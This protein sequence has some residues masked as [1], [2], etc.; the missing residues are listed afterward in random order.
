[1]PESILKRSWQVTLATFWLQPYFL[2]RVSHFMW[3]FRVFQLA[4]GILVL[5][6][7]SPELSGQEF[8]ELEVQTRNGAIRGLPISWGND[9]VLML[10]SDGWL[11]EFPTR[12]V[13]EHRLSNRSFRPAQA[14][15][16]SRLLTAELGPA[17]RTA[18]AG[19]FLI[20]APGS[21]LPI[22]SERFLALYSGFQNYCATRQITLRQ[23]SFLMPAIVFRTRQE[24]DAYSQ[25]YGHAVT[26]STLGYYSLVTNRIALY[27]FSTNDNTSDFFPT[28][29][30]LIHEATHQAAYNTGIHD[31]L[32]EQPLWTIEGLA[33]L[34]EAPGVYDSGRHHQPEKRINTTRLLGFRQFFPNAQSVSD[35]LPILL[36]DDKY[37]ERD[38]DRAYCLSWAL[39]Y[40]LSER[41]DSQYSAYLRS[42]ASRGPG[43]RYPADERFQQFEAS[44]GNVAIIAR[45]LHE[46]LKQ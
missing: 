27:E 14:E 18:V 12:E 40:F 13:V 6:G 45:D 36:T 44:F 10:R 23:P 25:R 34:F 3:A 2:S 21:S 7:G 39:T 11:A 17:Y 22:W 1:M 5:A 35:V 8:R 9:Q 30:T 37:F 38:P 24:F 41:Y 32:A 28:A 19:P 15:E 20:V 26:A 31:R 33:M 4:I 42:V 29:S 16:M 43:S 46:S